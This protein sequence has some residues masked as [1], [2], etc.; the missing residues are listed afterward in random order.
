MAI[1][2]DS[3]KLPA[4]WEID[5]IGNRMKVNYGKS[6]AG[7]QSL[8]GKFPIY[9]TGGLIGYGNTWL[10]HGDSVVIGRKGTLGNPIYVERPFWAVDT[11]YYTSD[12]VGSTKWF[13]YMLHMLDL[14]KW[15]EAT[16]VPSLSRVTFCGIE[17][18]FPPPPEQS[19]IAAILATVDRAIEQTEALIAK[20][21]R[22]KA[23]LMH[24]LLT[25][26]IDEHGQLRDPAT[27][28]FKPS[29]LGMI[30]EEWETAPIEDKLARI[31]D[32]RGRTPQKT[33]SGIPLITARNVRDGYLSPDPQEFIAEEK[34][35]QWMTRGIPS[36]GDVLFTTE[37]PMGNVARVPHYRIALAQRL[38]TLVCNG[39][40]LDS[41]FLFWFLHWQQTHERFER[42]TTGSTVV[43]IKQS[44]FRRVV[45]QFPS[46]RE[47]TE[48]A[49]I[50]DSHSAKIHSEQ[51]SLAK[52][53][54][55]KTGLMQDLLTGKVSVT[56][57]VEQTK[58]QQE[59]QTK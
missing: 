59:C 15:N 54:K 25:R 34:Y 45:L 9:G 55:L 30:P 42:M 53:H 58:E 44:V 48:I 14:V 32:Y 29:P 40:C 12:F 24:D 4:G 43:G 46:L 13:Y 50:L 1:H 10:S 38:L 7:I 56:A 27:H 49:T 8:D 18:P 28:K 22:I 2:F 6:Q 47:Q 51:L 37:A 41:G 23:G 5:R 19:T 31:M 26:G 11:T 17:I 3:V 57:L 36:P 16:G 52:L 21:Q 35:E 33:E 39:D 20:Y